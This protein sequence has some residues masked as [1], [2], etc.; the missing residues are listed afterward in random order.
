MQNRT[1][2]LTNTARKGGCFLEA[3]SGLFY[4]SLFVMKSIFQSM[5]ME[6]RIIQGGGRFLQTCLTNAALMLSIICVLAAEPLVKPV[7]VDPVSVVRITYENNLRIA[8]ARYEMEAAQ[9]QF[10]RFE[11]KLSQFTPFK[12]DTA[13]ERNST[14]AFEDSVREQE[15]V[16]Q[17]DTTVGF[18]K[19]FFDGKKI[20]AGVGVQGFSEDGADSGNP[21]FEGE[22]KVPLFSS[23]TRLER[24]TE[25]SFEE[26][27]MLQAWLDFIDR[28]NDSAN[29]S[30]KVY[31]ALQRAKNRRELALTAMNDLR[32]IL[33]RG[34]G[35]DI[36]GDIAQIE[37]Q[38]Q[39]YQSDAVENQGELE[40]NLIELLDNLGSD[41]LSLDDIDFLDYYGEYYYGR[42]YLD[43]KLE[44]L[45]EEALSSDIEVQIRE[46]ALE[47][48]KLKKLLAKQGKW[49]IIGKLFGRYDFDR[50][51]DDPSKKREYFVG[52]GVSIRRNDPK[53]MLLSMKQADAE[54]RRFDAEIMFRK[55]QVTN[56]ITR[57]IYEARSR[58]ELA[59][60][61]D[62]GRASRLA[63]FEQKRDEY[64]AKNETIEN[65]L[66]ARDDLYSTDR[67]LID[68]LDDLYEVIVELDATSGF[69]FRE[70]APQLE[71]LN[72]GDTI[73][74]DTDLEMDAQ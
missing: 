42:H 74:S 11:R 17:G 29:E 14:T 69:Y 34:G 24:I 71:S 50:K 7:V 51:G 58:R 9:F 10:D 55:R 46:I 35:L 37:G 52:A 22:I 16:D 63:L 39:E 48:A 47:N 21:F 38:I 20:A 33:N 43:A 1:S 4:L 54:I 25:R 57:L 32:A 66:K 36:S 60:E 72:K 31:F 30:Q 64:L 27:E 5:C 13:I 65:L 2:L 68:T 73:F 28:I 45:V 6:R 3:G 23:F 8:A 56:K 19:E 49:D 62:A 41:T 26:S 44:D 67:N 12:L 59:R 61:H 15:L 40:S 53:L 70:L 18:E